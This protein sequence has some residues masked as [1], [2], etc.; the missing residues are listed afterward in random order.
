MSSVDSCIVWSIDNLWLVKKFKRSWTPSA[1][2]KLNHCKLELEQT[3]EFNADVLFI[4]DSLRNKINEFKIGIEETGSEHIW[5]IDPE[6]NDDGNKVWLAKCRVVDAE[7]TGTRD[8]G[9][10]SPEFIYN[11]DLPDMSY[12]I[13]LDLPYHHYDFNYELVWMLDD[14]LHNDT[15]KIWAAK[16]IP[17]KS[18]GA[19]VQGNIGVRIKDFD[20]VFISYNEPNAEAN[21]YRVLEL[22]PTAK[23][24]K[25][26]K[27]IF[28]AHKRAAEI[29][30]TDMFYV[31]DGDAELV[32][33]W[34]FDYKPNVF[35]LDCVHLWTS[36]NPINDLEY[37]WGGIKL[38]PRQLL[39]DATT[40]RVDLTTGLG[41]LKYINKVSNITSFNT[42]AFGTWRS[43]FRECAK[44][45]SSLYQGTTT[46]TDTEQRL[47]IWT[48]MGKDRPYGE[49]ALQGAALG[50]Q[51]GLD[52]F[53]DLDALKLIN[54][55]E[56]MK[57]EFDKFYN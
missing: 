56:W 14:S 35:E 16:F 34:R 25:N 24:V 4:N 53:N 22:C 55:Y 15:D 23:R 41:K 38:F 40:W 42:D 7:I 51:Y 13:K 29:A 27:G 19:K 44:L 8:M 57:N 21:W 10:V 31:V 49:F 33:S 3:V 47:C 48:T 28:E 17:D 46:P 54:N 2:W 18:L 26:V 45:S 12:Y 36:I 9:Y 43:A 32:D 39:L 6:Y 11:P 20:V 52:N 50:K 30:T 1:G 37:G 5:Y